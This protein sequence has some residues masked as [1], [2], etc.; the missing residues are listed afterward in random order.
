MGRSTKK[1]NMKNGKI[2]FKWLDYNQKEADLN[3]DEQL[4]RQE[5]LESRSHISTR[6]VHNLMIG[7][8]MQAVADYKRYRK[9]LAYYADD[10]LHM[11]KGDR[12]VS[13]ERRDKIKALQAEIRE[14]EEFFH[15]EIFGECSGIWDGGK[16]IEAINRIPRSYDN[17]IRERR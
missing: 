5:N 6:G 14:C 4:I 13:S 11:K 12:F 9:A 10:L 7:V 16:V 8:C 17:Y 1:I 15:S 3:E 2:Q